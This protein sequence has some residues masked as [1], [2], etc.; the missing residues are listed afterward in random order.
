METE[1]LKHKNFPL[2][3][4]YF[5]C[6]YFGTLGFE[7]MAKMGNKGSFL[8]PSSLLLTLERSIF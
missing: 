6:I 2:Y 7:G 3:L 5:V 1:T 8:S 4:M